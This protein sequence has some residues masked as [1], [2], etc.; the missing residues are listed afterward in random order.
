MKK[1]IAIAVSVVMVLAASVCVF[2]EEELYSM[3]TTQGQYQESLPIPGPIVMQEAYSIIA[4]NWVGGGSEFNAILNAINTPDS[5]L[6][7][8]Y[9]GTINQFI[10]Q[11]EN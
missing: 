7:I 8:T 6:I 4:T 9:T 5:T 3:T 10:I 1:I 11:S 2:A